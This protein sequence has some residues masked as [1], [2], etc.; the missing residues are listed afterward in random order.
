[1]SWLRRCRN[2]FRLSR[3]DAEIE[4]ELQHHLAETVDRLVAKG[5][6]EAEAWR[7][8]RRKL[9]RYSYQKERTREMNIAGWLEDTRADLI[10]GARQLRQN[11]GFAAVAIFSLAL[12]IGANTA[13]FQLVNAIRL[14]TL[15]VENPQQLVAVDF[16]QGATRSGWWPTGR[17]T[18]TYGIW[19]QIHAQQQAF[20]DSMAWSQERF[21]LSNGGESRYAEG[22]Y[23]SGGF[24]RT[25]GVGAALGRV[26][27]EQDDGRSCNPAAVISDDFWRREFGGDPG[28]LGR[29]VTLDGRQYPVIGVT[30]PSFF[31]VEVGRRF[32][33]AIPL[34]VD[35][36]M[37]EDNQGRTLN[38]TAWWLL[39]LGRLKPGWTVESAEA[40]LRALSPGIMRATL[41]A[42]YTPDNARGYLANKLIAVEA[43]TGV[44][45]LRR[46]YERPLWVLM[47]IT[48]LV[49]LIACAN[50]ANLLLAR[51]AVRQQEIA[52]RLAIGASRWRLIRQLLAESLMLA[53]W[54]AALGVGLAFALSRMLV[55]LINS[56]DRPVYIDVALDWRALGFTIGLAALTC[57]LFGLAPALR[58]TSLSPIAALRSGGR[59]VT[60]GR[61]RFS[62]RRALVVTQI[63]LSLTLLHGALLFMRSLHNLE[64]VDA[65]FRPEGVLTI[66]V[67]LSRARYPE[68]Q[69]SIVF[70]E[71]ADRLA[72]LPGVL[73]V[74]QISFVPVAGGTWDNLIGPD[75]EAAAASGK[76]SFFNSAGPGYFKT[77]GT[78]LLTGRDFDDHDSLS[79]PKVAIVN[80]IFARKYFGGANP[81]GHT[82]HMSADAGKPEPSFQI[83]G[84]VGNTKYDQLRDDFEPI[85]FFPLSQDERIG[86][87][88][89]YVLRVGG[90]VGSIVNSSKAAVGAMHPLIGMQIRALSDQLKA[91]LV[92]EK[93][94]ATVSGG[95]GFLAG[96][97]ATLGLYGVIAY[98]VA[99]RRNEIGIRIALG[100]TRRQIISLVVRETIL[101]LALGLATGIGLSLWA[102]KA[103]STLLFG[104]QPHDVLS[105]TAA[106]GLLTLIAFLA[107]YA[108]ARRA[109]GVDAIETLRSE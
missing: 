11:P 81:V 3:V 33:V 77:M 9:G 40:H 106:S 89:S 37:A 105:L 93:L 51:A 45:R 12:G 78:R 34:C 13:I 64:T 27:E 2:V 47:A 63:A 15:P 83:V 102:G 30:S 90:G 7:E 74:A 80:E 55:A 5:M 69:R 21:N 87:N 14:K 10:Y 62:L 72:A 60:A 75:G 26:F 79:A 41:P 97:L 17:A 4:D 32:D 31:G 96:L 42:N 70:R 66:N 101:L 36:L 48:G 84:M 50:I 59:T 6:S 53:L 109:A 38:S 92:R 28:A 56:P 19:E 95:F 58:A 88:M 49:L 46:Q 8:A 1:M 39:M 91:S 71:I 61:E 23:V 43:G 22:M 98:M 29:S 107:A 100:A 76:S 68:T 25:L 44:S 35:R 24:F 67:D 54:S 85:A 65:G 52:V 94:M 104:L 57:I 103:T 20:S 99:R 86:T 73:S 82:F 18:M 108:P 16:D